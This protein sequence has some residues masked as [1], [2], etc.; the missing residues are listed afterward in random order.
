M[1]T[2][3]MRDAFGAALVEIGKSN[4]KLM[5]LDADVSSSTRSGLFGKAYPDRFF[6]VGVAEANMV[7]IAAGMATCGYRPVVSAFA[8][9]LALKATDQIRNVVCYNNLNV[10]IAGGYSGLSDSFD[11]ASHQSI[12]DLA[13]M[14]A[15]PNMTVLVPAHAD[16]V[17]SALEQA[18][19]INGPVY[20][21]MCRNPSPVLNKKPLMI[22][23][24]EIL[25]E[26]KNVTIGA[27]G[28]TIPMVLEAAGLLAE[29]GIAADVLDLGSLK[30]LDIDAIL[31]SA[32]K[33]GCFLTV[34]EHSIHGGLGSAV[35]EVLVKS[36]PVPMDFVGIDDCFTESGPYVDLLDKYGISVT[37]IV[38]KAE[39]LVGKTS[40]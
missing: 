22:G 7:D 17:T 23:K 39:A 12:T 8:I 35:S 5:V 25:A 2:K 18:L 32:K 28:I 21:R 40:Q 26:G 14:R 20:I 6:N 37:A 9:F 1:E 27:C 11:G 16:D 34:E 4:D 29:K 33:T 38:A 13:I 19:N 15:F 31:T 30:P 24:A 10:I 36:N 3:G